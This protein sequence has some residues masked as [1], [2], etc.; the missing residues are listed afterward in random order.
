[1]TE[2]RAL[3]IPAKS[4]SLSCCRILSDPSLLF[5]ITPVTKFAKRGILKKA[6]V[7]S[8]FCFGV[9]DKLMTENAK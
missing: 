4:G 2:L 8:V 3:G 7:M 1:M 5:I 9:E 6:K